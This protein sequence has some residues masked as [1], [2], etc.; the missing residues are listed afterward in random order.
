[1]TSPSQTSGIYRRQVLKGG[2][3]AVA[4]A[5]V[6]S[7]VRAQETEVV[8][9]ASGGAIAAAF[10][11]NFFDP[12]TKATGI[13]VR[14]VPAADAEMLTK[15][16]AMNESGKIEW[17]IVAAN[18]D[19]IAAFQKY[20]AP[21]DCNQLA[22]AATD[23]IPGA[24]DGYSV[25][26]Q[27]DGHA[28]AFSTKAYPA[29]SKQ[30][31]SWAD[32]WDVK[33]FPGARSL[34]DHGTPWVPIAAALMADG[35]GAAQ[36]KAPLDID[37]AL[38]KLDEIKPHVKVWWRTGDQSQQVAR[39]GEVTMI[40]MYSGRALRS[41][42]QGV[43]LDIT[44]N[45]AVMAPGRWTVLKGA[46]NPKAAMAFLDYFLTRP[47]AHAAFTK[48]IFYDTANKRSVEFLPDGER[49]NSALYGDNLKKTVQLDYELASWLGTHHDR[50]LERWNGWIA[51]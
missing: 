18:L 50:L 17:D 24:C 15:V 1:M 37:R 45:Q 14:F 3:A 6:P 9:V 5:A 7:T 22:H 43:P 49:P 47:E 38:K 28:L 29:G 26:K 32:F 36:I 4:A 51:K 44:W 31:Q 35:L 10:K 42:S 48:Q 20:F 11:E 46:P 33:T 40:M 25:L 12:F 34:P 41:K 2:L 19:Q 39:D 27:L 8:L 23:G 30:P 16:K 21:L 13:K